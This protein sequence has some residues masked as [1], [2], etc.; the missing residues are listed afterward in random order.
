M[1]VCAGRNSGKKRGLLFV[2]QFL[3]FIKNQQ[4][5]MLTATAAPSPSQ[6]FDP[7]AGLQ[8]DLLTPQR[9]LDVF[10]VLRQHRRIKKRRH[11]LERLRRGFLKMSGVY[12]H[13]VIQNHARIG[14]SLYKTRLAVL[15]RNGQA[16]GLSRPQS[17]RSQRHPIVQYVDLPRVE[18]K[19]S[20]SQ[21]RGS[22]ESV[23]LS[24]LRRDS[25]GWRL[26]SR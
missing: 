24:V 5:A 14:A 3:S 7:R 2:I 10:D 4:I 15:P 19:P 22:V 17:G 18:R 21:D 16:A 9:R 12:H 20:A 6:E 11:L 26:T 25:C 23:T 1:R 13:F 8:N